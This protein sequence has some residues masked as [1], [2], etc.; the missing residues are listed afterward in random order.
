M[1]AMASKVAIAEV[2]QIVEV[3][4]IDPEHVVTPGSFIDR[5]IEI[6]TTGLGTP[7]KG[8]AIIEQLTQLESV[9]DLLFGK[10]E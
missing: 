4:D 9:R 5:I 10:T 7:E 2:E 8:R 3:G 1:M 6:P